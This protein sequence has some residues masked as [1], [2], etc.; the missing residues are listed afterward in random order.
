M[1]LGLNLRYYWLGA[2]AAV[3]LGA[4][5]LPAGSTY[6]QKGGGGTTPPPNPAIVFANSGI[7]VMNA[8]GTNVRTVVAL[9][10]GEG[11]TQPC[12]GPTGSEIVFSGGFGG[13]SGIYTVNL[14]GTNRQLIVPGT[15]QQPK[16]SGHPGPN[17]NCLIAFNGDGLSGKR[18]IFVV[19]P[20]GTG[21]LNVTET[22]TKSEYYCAW[23]R[24]GS[25]LYILGD[26]VL[27]VATL[28]LDAAGKV[29][30][31]SR[32]VVWDFLSSGINMVDIEPSNTADALAFRS[33][34][35]SPQRIGILDLASS[36]PTYRLVTASTSGF[37]QW[38]CYS[39]DDTKIV[40][41][42]SGKTGG[43][44]TVN[45]DGTGEVRI[46]TAGTNPHWKRPAPAGP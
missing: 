23:A 29:V 32:D 25:H 44:F 28:G 36:P 13:V 39:P 18:D 22:G 42:R 21:R 30:V 41:Y 16:W 46:A 8:D 20:D 45:V 31:T 38:P 7:K 15:V 24:D 26:Y 4:I 6:A 9:G 40:F 5:L 14:D 27:I 19:N 10:R 35:V 33:S 3:A 12:W 34:N 1:K 17:G 11:A 43:I 37:E 2:A